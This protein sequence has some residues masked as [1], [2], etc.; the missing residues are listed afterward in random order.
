[1]LHNR[2]TGIGVLVTRPAHQAGYLIARISEL[3]GQPWLF[4]VLEISD[5]ENR[6]SLLD[7]V[8]R[9][10]DFDLA[11]FVS[12]NAVEK[13]MPLIQ[14]NRIWPAHTHIAVVGAGSARILERYGITDVIVP[15]DGSDSEAL[16]R[17]P[18]LQSMQGRRVVI[19]RGNG[20]R[21]LLG[22]TLRQRGASVEYAE[23]YRRCKPEAD[24]LSL[25]QHWCKNG[26]QAVIV[27]SSEGL[28]NLFDMIGETGQQLLKN[29]VLFTAHDRIVRK[30]KERGIIKIYRT[31]VG[32]E[33]TMQGLLKYFNDMQSH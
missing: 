21:K 25:L 23:C 10:D 33:G 2:L 32:D 13:T 30:A 20:G 31:P 18:Q 26:I 7:L 29:T 11:I 22:D 17:M 15:D 9:F 12:P 14:A 19:F 6:Q 24:P 5:S 16:L 4:P 8:A 3:G 1:M 27:T 28:D